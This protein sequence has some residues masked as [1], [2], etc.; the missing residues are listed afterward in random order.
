[1]QQLDFELAYLA[2]LTKAGLKPL[3]RWEKGADPNTAD[4]LRALGL[5]TR[6]VE[7][8]VA[9]GAR[10]GE[11]IF[12][13]SERCLEL[14]AARFDHTPISRDRQSARI[15]GL[16]FGYPSCCVES[17][18]ARGYV[19]NALKPRDQRILFHWA[20][21]NCALTPLL[22]PHYRRLYRECR[23]AMRGGQLQGSAGRPEPP[24]AQQLKGAVAMAAAL[25]ALGSLPAAWAQG[26]ANPDPHWLP[27]ALWEDPDGDLLAST[28]E[29]ILGLDPNYAHQNNSLEVDGVALARGLSQTIDA[30]PTEPSST[31]AYVVH[32]MAFGLETCQVCGDSSI[33]MGFMEVVNPQTGESC[34]IPYVGKH[35][36]EHGSFSYSGSV[37]SGRV[38]PPRLQVALSGQGDD[39]FIR[40]L[41]D[42]DQDRLSD[43]EEQDLKTDPQN[44]DEDQDGIVDGLELARDLA[45]EISALPTAP[46]TMSVYR[47]DFELKGLERCAGCGETVNMGHL[48][49]C[50]PQAELYAK[51]P[52]IALHYLEHGNFS[53]AGDVHGLGRADVK[54]LADA[55][56]SPGPSHLRK[57]RDDTDSDGLKDREEDYFKTDKTIADTGLDGVPDGF[58]LAR[59]LGQAV[60]ALPRQTNDTCYAVDHMLRGLV[61]CDVCGL[62][63]N[64]GWVEV[65]NPKENLNLQVPYLALHAMRNGSFA[66]TAQDRLNPV[67]LDLALR[68]DGTSHQV[69]VAGDTDKDGLLDTE[70]ACFGLAA[71]KPDSDG[72]GVPDGTAL[73]RKLHAQVQALPE[74]PLA[75][76]TYIV[77]AEA[78]CYAPCPVCGQDIN[79]GHV[80]VTSP[81]SGLSLRIAYLNLHYL[82]RGSLASS[83]TSRV[84]PVLLAAILRPAVLISATEGQ[85]TL[86]WNGVAGR[87]YQVFTASEV[88]GPW[89]PGPLVSGGGQFKFTEPSPAGTARKFYRVIAW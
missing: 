79:C 13:E 76:Q 84:D 80:E 56:R 33:N 89:Q 87:S 41:A 73:A 28:E 15:E 16:L 11:L 74:G 24:I 62:A 61:Y 88:A 48:T 19:K 40:V 14:Y 63:L 47:R 36:L 72:D 64:M 26:Q 82:E 66:Y 60:E 43:Q 68:G 2:L 54:L 58:G 39:H 34:S 1:M 32:Y 49:V 83:P 12:S 51:L 5:K 67:L 59:E 21:A 7:R 42:T 9:S 4:A 53:F 71:D 20:C 52:Y 6:V 70:E 85:V 8:S 46:T 78:D 27:L 77:R 38:A 22:T 17:Y 50:N 30:L 86:C 75:D 18:A 65:I 37:H 69:L 45:A 81:W 35:F 31:Q 55:L 44:P 23:H 3:S 10:V 29:A 25:V 57:V